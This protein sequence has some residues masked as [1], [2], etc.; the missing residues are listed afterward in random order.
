MARTSCV[1]TILLFLVITKKVF[2]RQLK[3]L[4]SKVIQRQLKILD[5]KTVELRKQP[6]DFDK[7]KLGSVSCPA[8]GEK[9]R[10]ACMGDSLTQ[11]KNPMKPNYPPI[12]QT[13]LGTKHFEVKNFG[14]SGHTA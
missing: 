6:F 14:K 12:L 3:I 13:F 9:I 4:D 5:P 10:I 2:Q 1:V 8:K 7:T 11:R